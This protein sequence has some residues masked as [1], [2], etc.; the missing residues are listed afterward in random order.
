[1]NG[2]TVSTARRGRLSPGSLADAIVNSDTGR[3]VAVWL[4][5][6][7]IF[8]VVAPH[9]MSV[10]NFLNLGL[11]MSVQGIAAMGVTLA[12]I[13]GSL[14]LSFPV[15]ISTSVVVLARLVS[16]GSPEVP[17]ILVV[18][19]LGGAIGLLNGVLCVRLRIDALLITLATNTALANALILIAQMRQTAL[20][21]D[22]F[23]QMGRGR[24]AGVPY[25]ALLLLSAFAVAFVFLRWSIPGQASFAVGNNPVAARNAGLPVD[26]IR[27]LLLIISGIFAAFAGVVMVS[28]NG[29]ATAADGDV[30][31]LPVLAAV[32][33]GGASLR[34]GKGSVVA[35]LLGLL[36]LAT[37]ENGLNILN[38]G[39]FVKMV[40][41][42]A[43]V[44]LALVYYSRFGARR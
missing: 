14:D 6:S 39:P 27:I 1:M 35:T 19:A 3:L 4:V 32:I 17:S 26:R 33:L 31:L 36:I 8:A 34:G 37:I 38:V 22:F 7:A 13:S 9:F 25:P 5:I 2:S 23:E 41:I 10:S 20:P 40:V 42:G 29:Y 44:L 18:L 15:V 21:G 16:G 30:L 28:V 43:I 11:A 12:L 24:L